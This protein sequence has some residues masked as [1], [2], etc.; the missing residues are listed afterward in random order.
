ML[1][2][3]SGCS[4]LYLNRVKEQIIN[5]WEFLSSMF[6]AIQVP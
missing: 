1:S 6:G 4:L 5:I 2:G 3:F